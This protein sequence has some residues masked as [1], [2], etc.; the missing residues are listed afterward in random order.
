MVMK[1]GASK[2]GTFTTSPSN[3]PTPESVSIVTVLVDSPPMTGS[4][5]ACH[6]CFGFENISIG[7]SVAILLVYQ[8]Y[9]NEARGTK[10]IESFVTIVEYIVDA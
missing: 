3:I 7:I 6:S 5:L 10:M 2:N 4:F 8:A 1:P 9:L